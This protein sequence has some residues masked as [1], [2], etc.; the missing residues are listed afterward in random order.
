MLMSRVI[1]A[2]LTSEFRQAIHG[3]EERPDLGGGVEGRA[4]WPDSLGEERFGS[5]PRPWPWPRPQ[6]I[7]HVP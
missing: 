5:S 7:R 2:R 6:S 3:L 4:S 1:L